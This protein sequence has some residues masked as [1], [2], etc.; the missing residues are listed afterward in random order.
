MPAAK[1]GTRA[2]EQK[3]LPLPKQKRPVVAAP[4]PL[5]EGGP[6]APMEGRHQP[7]QFL[8]WAFHAFRLKHLGDRYFDPWEGKHQKACKQ[9]MTKARGD[10]GEVKRRM[11]NLWCW[12]ADSPDFYR[13]TPQCLLGRWEDLHQSPAAVAGGRAALREKVH[14]AERERILKE[15][16]D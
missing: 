14:N 12:C 10:H 4:Q 6:K 11:V 2:P 1:K 8:A 16:G 13:F 9:I 15:L 5:F 3:A 7:F